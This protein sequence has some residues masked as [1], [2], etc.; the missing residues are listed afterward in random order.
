MRGISTHYVG[1]LLAALQLFV[2][3]RFGLVAAI[4]SN[5]YSATVMNGYPL[6]LDFSAWYRHTGYALLAIWTIVVLYAFHTSL[7]GRPLLDTSR[8][9]E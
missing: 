6:T 3:M 5:F 2:L 9:E 7:G 8:L 1:L 4:I